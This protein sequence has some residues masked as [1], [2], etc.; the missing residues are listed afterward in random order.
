MGKDIQGKKITSQWNYKISILKTCNLIQVNRSSEKFLNSNRIQPVKFDPVKASFCSCTLPQLWLYDFKLDHIYLLIEGYYTNTQDLVMVYHK[1]FTKSPVHPDPTIGSGVQVSE[2]SICN[3]P[4]LNLV[5]LLLPPASEGW[6][7]VIFSVCTP[8]QVRGGGGYPILGLRWGERYPSQVWD[9][10]G[11]TLTRSRCWG[12]GTPARSRWWGVP[13][14][15]GMR[16]SP[17]LGWGTPPGPGMGYPPDLGW[18]TPQNLGWGTP[19]TWDGVTPPADLRWGTPP[20]QI[21]IASTCYTAGVC[22]LHSRRRTFLYFTIFLLYTSP[23]TP[24]WGV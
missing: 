23:Y 13:P 1:Y 11:G 4:W 14:H 6:G 17:D 20:R 19:R 3:T 15:P 12:G 9:G 16:Y 8:S 2:W 18:G 22:L 7:K 5:V 10:C 21:S 24:Q